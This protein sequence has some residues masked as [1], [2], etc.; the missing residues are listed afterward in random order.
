MRILQRHGLVNRKVD[1]RVMHCRLAKLS[2]RC[3]KL[4]LTLG[5]AEAAYK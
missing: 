4:Q 2:K 1:G 3:G 5:R